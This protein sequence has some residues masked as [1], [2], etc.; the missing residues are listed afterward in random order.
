M[1]FYFL[2]EIYVRHSK[3]KSRFSNS[4]TKS[5]RKTIGYNKEKSPVLSMQFTVL[6]PWYKGTIG[7]II[8]VFIFIIA[9]AVIYFLYKK[10]IRKEQNLLKLM[11]EEAQKKL[12]EERKQENEKEI[13]R[14]KNESLKN[15][16]KLKTTMTI[17]IRK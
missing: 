3:N 2:K 6:S 1:R 14:L 11:F 13:I 9:S 7:F 15:E 5:E 8:Y 17:L 12:L 16:I 4:V 10:K